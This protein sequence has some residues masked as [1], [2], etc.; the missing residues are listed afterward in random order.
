VKYKELNNTSIYESKKE[1]NV[2]SDDLKNILINSGF[3]IFLTIDQKHE[4][5]VV[6]LDLTPTIVLIIGNPEIGTKLMNKYPTITYD[7]PIKIVITHDE[8]NN[9]I[10][11]HPDFEFMREQHK[12]DIPLFSK[13]PELIQQAV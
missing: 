5:N 13:L 4:A 3:K 11:L 10:V 7:L 2:V 6:D 8:D 1:V 12:I 9:T